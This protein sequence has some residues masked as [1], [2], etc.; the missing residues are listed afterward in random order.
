MVASDTTS[1]A[2][3]ASCYV[4]DVR[5]AAEHGAAAMHRMAA[6]HAGLYFGA[7]RLMAALNRGRWMQPLVLWGHLAPV[8]IVRSSL[9]AERSTPITSLSVPPRNLY[10][11]VTVPWR[12]L[13]PAA[14]RERGLI[15][16]HYVKIAKMAMQ[17][18]E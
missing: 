13:T 4:E 10:P 12:L 7:P 11:T 1:G 6:L 2:L 8:Y 5:T 14:A 9:C 3:A 18:A 16:S 15:P 17:G